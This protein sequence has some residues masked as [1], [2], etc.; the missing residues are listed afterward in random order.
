[1]DRQ[2]LNEHELWK[3]SFKNKD[4]SE[5]EFCV[6]WRT[7]CKLAKLDPKKLR[8]S[9]RL[10]TFVQKNPRWNLSDEWE[11]VLIEWRARRKT[12]GLDIEET[13]LNTIDTVV[14]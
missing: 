5:E 10:E 1:C 6:A 4:I 2:N 3:L 8:P 12:C 13:S 11:D 14:R 9:D 7:I